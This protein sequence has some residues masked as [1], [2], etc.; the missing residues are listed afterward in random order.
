LGLWFSDAE[1]EFGAVT[2]NGA[3]CAIA[4]LM[5]K[6]GVLFNDADGATADVGAN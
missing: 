5:G 4:E 3:D 2:R 6:F 1:A